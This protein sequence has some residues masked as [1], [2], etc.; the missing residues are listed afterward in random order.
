MFLERLQDFSGICCEA[1]SPAGAGGRTSNRKLIPVSPEK[2]LLSMRRR[3]EST[4]NSFPRSLSIA[5]ATGFPRPLKNK[6]SRSVPSSAAR[7]IFGDRSCRLVKYMYLKDT[8]GHHQFSEHLQMVPPLQGD[9]VYC[10]RN[11]AI[12]DPNQPLGITEL[13]WV[14]T[15]NQGD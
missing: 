5:R 1:A 7:S 2:S 6:T 3:S 13:Q 12:T 11:H 15:T 14:E 9:P 8:A 10:W 4:Q